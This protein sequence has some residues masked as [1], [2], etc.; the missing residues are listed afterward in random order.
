MIEKKLGAERIK[1]WGEDFLDAGEIN[2]A[3]FGSW[4]VPVDHQAANG[5]DREEYIF[6]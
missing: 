6:S 1:L 5:Q 3:V 2:L 4:M